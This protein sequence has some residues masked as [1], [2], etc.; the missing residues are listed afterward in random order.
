LARD[1]FANVTGDLVIIQ[2]GEFPADGQTPDGALF[3][4]HWD[5]TTSTFL[6]MKITDST[7]RHLEHS[8]FAPLSLPTNP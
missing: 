4:V 5:S 8:V 7:P 2:S 6:K 1:Y 3:L